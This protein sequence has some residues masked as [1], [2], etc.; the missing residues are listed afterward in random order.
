[1][2]S[3]RKLAVTGYRGVWGE[4]LNEQIAFEYI[5]A[6]A[7]F[8][9]SK[10]G[11]KILI[12]RDTRASGA[13]I[14]ACAQEAFKKEGVEMVHAGI[15]PTPSI[16]LLVRKLNLDGGLMITASHN[17]IQ[18]NG[19]K[20]IV[21]G[22]RMI[23]EGEVLEIESF[24]G[25]MSD[26][27]KTPA[28]SEQAEVN[29]DNSE[30]RKIHLDEI[31]KHIDIPKIR[32]KKF[33]VALDSI[34][35][36]GSVITQ[37]LLKE[38]GCEVYIINEVQDG[39]F[40]HIP[41][42]LPENLGQIATEVLERK[43]DIGFAQDP[44]ADRLVVVNEKG[45]VISEE[46]TLVFVVKNI[47][48]KEKG[49]VV[50]NIQTSRMNEELAKKYNQPLLY[51]KVGEGNL[52]ETMSKVNAIVGGEGGG[53]AIYPKIN[54]ARDS[55]VGIALILELLA[56]ENKKVSEIVEGL[57][58]YVS[59]KAKIPLLEDVSIVYKKLKE[60]FN[61]ATLDESDGVCFSWE[62]GAWISIRPSTTEPLIR[63]IGEAK[64]AERIE[65]ILEQVK[66]TL[67]DK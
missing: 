35:G 26:E 61:D 28:L 15:M 5:R 29:V 47:L 42:P 10:G 22:G 34:N 1:M 37:E 6:F 18:Y 36:T 7:K 53:G 24:R 56:T 45:V 66:L 14:L 46:Y 31:L 8:I 52:I 11:K 48:N 30:F 44:D 13:N 4:S 67:N 27:D 20:F 2:T 63:I 50:V 57:P 39:N 16:L 17:P 12:G 41:E 38:L 32:E 43:A 19:I 59:K 9:K 40:A 65:S 49:T 25:G 33:K 54:T 21:K 55:L 51:A 62:D 60:R 58:I 64:T 23:N 3:K